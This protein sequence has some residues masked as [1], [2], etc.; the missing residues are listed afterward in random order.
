MLY[1]IAGYYAVFKVLHLQVKNQV[2]KL[3]KST[4]PEQDLILFSSDIKSS[5]EFEWVNNHEFR[6]EG[7]LYDIIRT[8]SEGTGIKWHCINDQQEEQILQRLKQQ[9]HQQ[10]GHP[11]KNAKQLAKSLVK[12]YI[13]EHFT[14]DFYTVFS[15]HFFY[16]R[17][18][19]LYHTYGE[20]TA[21]PPRYQYQK[22]I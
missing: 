12:D 13:F 22:A 21:P 10:N 20:Q 5:E 14:A 11:A 18:N 2:W 3:Q 17:M 1:N 7:A 9:V 15:K 16:P 4:I 19:A 6:F 8:S